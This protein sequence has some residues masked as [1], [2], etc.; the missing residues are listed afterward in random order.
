MQQPKIIN[1]EPSLKDV[2]DAHKKDIFFTFNTH[3]IATIESFDP[4]NQ[5]CVAKINYDKMLFIRQENGTFRQTAVPYPILTDVPVVFLSGGK[6]GLTFPVQKGDQA[7]IAFNDRD[8]DNWNEGASNGFVASLRMHS[9][10]DGIAIVGLHRKTNKIAGFRMNPHLFNE[11][12]GIEVKASKVNL[13]N[14]SD[15]L[16]LLLK[17]LIDNVK[18]LVT[19]TAAITVTCSAPGNPSSPPINA[20]AINA[21]TAQLTSTASKI[22]GLLE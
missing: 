19:A 17:D 16:G 4:A 1:T 21:V 12:T 14:S 2:L 18:D 6:S 20:A 11:T 7:L 3:A 22:Q 8:I 10:S 5:T 15:S 9:L 13:Y